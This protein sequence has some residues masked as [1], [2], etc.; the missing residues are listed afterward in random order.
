MLPSA[1]EITTNAGSLANT[2]APLAIAWHVAVAGSLV[3][4]AAGWR[5]SVRLVLFALAIPLVT[6]SAAAFAS[7]NPVN[8]TAFLVLAVLLAVAGEGSTA[9]HVHRGHAWSTWFGALLIVYALCYPHFVTGAWY[10]VIAA[11]P[12][13]VLPCPTLALV[14]GFVMLAGGFGSRGIP[15]V[16]AIWAGLYAYVGVAWLGVALDLGLLLAALALLALA[17]D[18]GAGEHAAVNA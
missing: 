2:L 15:A 3:A 13:G 7:H 14:A 10:R 18:H 16:L 11:A 1:H 6:V 5:P 12:I 9:Q 8:G 4:V 17:V